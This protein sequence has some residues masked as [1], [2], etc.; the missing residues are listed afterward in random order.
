M[1]Y[2][3]VVQA[4]EQLLKELDEETDQPTKLSA[5]EGYYWEGRVLLN[6]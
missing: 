4:H 6:N 5:E 1:L 3:S 2:N